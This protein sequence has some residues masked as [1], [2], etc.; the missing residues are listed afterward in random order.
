[1]QRVATKDTN[2]HVKIEEKCDESKIKENYQK[3][4]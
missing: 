2:I 1:V 4:Q 3:Q